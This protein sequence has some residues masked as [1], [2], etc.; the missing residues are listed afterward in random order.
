M[1]LETLPALLSGRAQGRQGVAGHAGISLR[2][3]SGWQGP[4]EGAW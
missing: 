4:P 1:D 2:E 3:R